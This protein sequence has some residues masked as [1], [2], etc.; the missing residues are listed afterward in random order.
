VNPGEFNQKVD[1]TL[2]AIEDALEAC[3]V[4]LDWDFA[5]GILTIECDNG[6]QVIINRQEP[7]RQIWLAARAGGFHFDYDNTDGCW[8]QDELELFALL[9]QCLSEQ[10]GE[11]VALESH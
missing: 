2:S 9:N 8:K 11:T 3:D 10:T 6:S 5:G 1:E 4:D 7:T